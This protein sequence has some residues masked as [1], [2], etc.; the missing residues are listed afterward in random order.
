M[1]ASEIHVGS[2]SLDISKVGPVFSLAWFGATALELDEEGAGDDCDDRCDH[3]W[4]EAHERGD[5]V[6]N[7]S[8]V[9]T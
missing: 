8:T 1:T 7:A 5:G 6:E 2:S 9:A 3:V 4:K